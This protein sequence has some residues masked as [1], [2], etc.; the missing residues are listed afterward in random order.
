MYGLPK[1]HTPGLPYNQRPSTA[2][3]EGTSGS[4]QSHILKLLS[5]F[6][7]PRT[8]DNSQVPCIDSALSS[9]QLAW[10]DT[11]GARPRALQ[12]LSA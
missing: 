2:R 5:G 11:T 12:T 1:L 10:L 8:P 3:D 6:S 7:Q 4:P 9:R